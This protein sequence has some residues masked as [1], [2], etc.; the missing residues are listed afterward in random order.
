M[1]NC[2]ERLHLAAR[3]QLAE[4][5][6]DDAGQEH[7]ALPRIALFSRQLD[8][9][10]QHAG[11]LDD[12][13]RVAAAEGVLAAESGDEVQRLV[14]DLRERVRRVETHGHQERPHLGLEEALDPAPLGAGALGVVDDADAARR[15]APA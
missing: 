15:P 3:E 14:G 10:R 1:R 8:D 4:V 5:G 6:A 11:D 13:H 2:G 7:E 12:G 9:A